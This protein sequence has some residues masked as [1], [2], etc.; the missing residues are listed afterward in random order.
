M[1][2]ALPPQGQPYRRSGIGA[3]TSGVS[4]P[5]F[6][7]FRLGL[8]ACTLGAGV[9]A[10][11]ALVAWRLRGELPPE[12]V[13]TPA[14][15]HAQPVVTRD[16]Y[17]VEAGTLRLADGTA[18]AV[19][20]DDELNDRRRDTPTTRSL[21]EV[22]VSEGIVAAL[23]P[24]LRDAIHRSGAEPGRA[25]DVVLTLDGKLQEHLAARAR[26]F[27]GILAACVDLPRALA[28]D[29]RLA[30]GAVVPRAAA[31]GFIVVREE[32]GEVQAIGGRYA[33]CAI[34]ALRHRARQDA[35]GRYPIF[36]DATAAC[37]QF[38]D[39]RHAEWL[40]F[41]PHAY[42]SLRPGESLPGQTALAARD[43]SLAPTPSGSTEKMKLAIACELAGAL[44]E[45]DAFLKAKWAASS[46]NDFFKS[47]S[48]RCVDGY[49]QVYGRL[50]APASLLKPDGTWPADGLFRLDAWPRD[51]PAGPTLS[52]AAF[53]ALD[54]KAARK[55][56]KRLSLPPGV[57]FET[58]E[59]SRAIATLA[60]GDG[61]GEATLA[62]RARVMRQIGLAASG[63]A[64]APALHLARKG[65]GAPAPVPGE[66]GLTVRQANRVLSFL[67]GVTAPGGTA[68]A[69]C[70]RVLGPPACGSAGV[71]HLSGKT[72][73]SDVAD[74]SAPQHVRKGFLNPIPMKHFVVR[75][76]AADG[77]HY[78]VAAQAIRARDPRTGRLDESNPAAE[79]GLLVARRLGLS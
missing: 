61:G 6:Q 52:P 8:L 44:H 67:S 2:Y 57:A 23:Q 47:L 15:A 17:L 54:G 79:F 29:P 72:G 28:A 24:L 30:Q 63:R 27:T 58:L 18:V 19:S 36:P 42:K 69:A 71:A 32:S 49:R 4:L 16:P 41:P 74:P 68:R 66:L 64:A 22:A 34:E 43:F 55:A 77:H 25:P 12:H 73:T 50:A 7:R 5:L 62:H 51:L 60:I 39:A 76:R 78:I 59:R 11:G 3:A 35:A 40:G 56:R 70:M 38:P 10:T 13:S 31:V 65:T 14:G 45:S 53:I 48:L 9:L 26:C 75:F 1:S 20:A 37:A 33:A 21:P 46:D